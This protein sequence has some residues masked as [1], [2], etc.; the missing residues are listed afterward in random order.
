M[1]VASFTKNLEFHRLKC[2]GLVDAD[3]RGG[4]ARA[5]ERHAREMAEYEAKLAARDAKHAAS[6]RADSM[7]S[8]SLPRMDLFTCNSGSSTIRRLL[9]RVRSV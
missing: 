8:Q 2:A 3:G 4:E 1:Q 5:K 9:G 7:A 6:L